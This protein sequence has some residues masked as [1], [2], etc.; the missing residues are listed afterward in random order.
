MAQS[1]MPDWMQHGLEAALNDPLAAPQAAVFL[2]QTELKLARS[3]ALTDKLLPLLQNADAS[4]RL[5]ASVSLG[6]L[7]TDDDAPIV[8]DKLLA[9]IDDPDDFVRQAAATSLG[10]LPA[11]DRA[12]RIFAKLVPL[13]NERDFAFRKIVATTLGRLAT[14]EQANRL[15]D[16]LLSFLIAHETSASE[17]GLENLEG[18]SRD[19]AVDK[20]LLLLSNPDEFVRTWAVI[21]LG[22]LAVGD[23]ANV[24][25][26]KLL[27]LLGDPATNVRAKAAQMIGELV[28]PARATSIVGRLVPLLNDPESF[29]RHMAVHSLAKIR[30]RDSAE[31]V[32]ENLLPVLRDKDEYVASDAA[33]AIGALASEDHANTAFDRLLPLLNENTYL[34]YGAANGLRQLARGE[35]ASRLV[36]HLLSIASDRNNY[37]R[38]DAV[39][40]LG[41]FTSPD[42][43]SDVIEKLLSLCDSNSQIREEAVKALTRIVTPDRTEDAIDKL[44]PLLRDPE[45]TVRSEAALALGRLAIG[46][47]S[48]RAIDNLVP[49]L[50]DTDDYIR[51]AAVK[52]LG[53]LAT[54]DRGRGISDKLLPLLGDERVRGSAAES[55]ERIATGVHVPGLTEKL[56]PFMRSEA[57]LL[58]L[59]HVLVQLGPGDV[60]TAIVGIRLV[61]E[62]DL[63]LAG[64]VRAVVHIATAGADQSELL[65]RWFGQAR[66]P[67]ISD[68]SNK[69]DE[70][71]KILTLLVQHWDEIAKTDRLRQEVESKTIEIINAACQR[72]I[73][74]NTL[75]E[76]VHASIVWVLEVPAY[77]P[78]QNCWT[79][80]QRKTLDQLHSK[81]TAAH[82]VHEKALA[83]QLAHE[84]LAP[85]GRWLTWSIL[86]W[87]VFWLTFLFV[88]PWSP[89]VQAMFFWNPRIRGVLSLWFMPLL[90]LAVSP[91]RKRLLAPM[92]ETLVSAARLDQFPQ[93]AFFGRTQVRVNGGSPARAEEVLPK[94]RGTVVIRGD[95]GLGK[96]ST[97]RWLAANSVEPVAFLS[98]RDCAAG[99]DT[100]IARLIHD[101][102]ETGFVRS[103]IHAG[104]LIVM[105]DG[106]NEVS[107]STREKISAFAGEMS[108]G[109]IFLSTQPIE[110][111]IPQRACVVDLQPLDRSDAERFLTSRPVGSD[112]AS[113]RHGPSYVDAVQVFLRNSL[114]KAPSEDE[115]RAAEQILSNPFDLAFAADLLAQGHMPKATFL[116][117]EAFH[118]ADEGEPGRP[119]YRQIAGQTF[120]LVKFGRHAVDMKLVDRNWF[121]PNEFAAELACLLERRLLVRRAVRANESVEDRIQFRHDRVWD[122]F[123]A[124]AFAADPDLMLT[125][126]ADPRFR[127]A[128]L[129]IAETWE[130]DAAGQLLEQLVV[131]AAERGDHST[132]DE[133]VKRLESRRRT[134]R[135]HERSRRTAT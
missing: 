67:P 32:I 19:I 36:D 111:N 22:Y 129:R 134:K 50:T 6:R 46:D 41:D 57:G 83:D 38:N 103:M 16:L 102:Q 117:D 107:A 125:H 73:E 126:L 119:G 78:V 93:L 51:I 96:T 74:A 131:V 82:S 113:T 29:V 104:T 106:L 27:P 97:L 31:I 28:S 48:S 20:L 71:H 120:P 52:S 91:L 132:S 64:Q 47:R 11:G 114:D 13:M 8:I 2:S 65:L 101:V 69:P 124:A 122:F 35:R 109:Q 24:V 127:G 88:F 116:I 81:F 121:K 25:V 43:T 54:G 85:L 90:L 34:R 53:A 37:K 133:F 7:T 77:G 17:T 92:R 130:P 95:A 79:A 4:V 42:R 45:R 135:R 98:A 87:A 30:P 80:E 112:T 44:L 123:I 128:Y 110:W 49:L 10:Q 68:I 105:V 70:A 5:D 115:R 18:A 66:N 26:D 100:A 55:L 1:S 12:D 99:V 9:L 63:S 75:R 15:V 94:L 72:A 3:A 61:N 33:E 39:K 21:T 84:D 59:S 56:L 89:T 40:L 58:D 62:S 86:G 108:K 60:Q 118:L 14:G 76:W 23:R